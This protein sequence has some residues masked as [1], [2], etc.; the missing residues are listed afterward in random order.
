MQSKTGKIQSIHWST[1]PELLKAI[2]DEFGNYFDPCPLNAQFN[3]LEIDWKETNFINPPYDRKGKELFIRKAYAEWKKGKTC[4]LLIPVSTSTKIFHELIYGQAEIRFI[5]K[6]IKFGGS[7]SCGTFDSML[8]IFRGKDCEK[9]NK[10]K[11]QMYEGL[12]E[13]VENL[14]SGWSYEVLE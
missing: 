2:R 4:I 9:S 1:P 8:V 10:I 7:K 6:R 11:I 14:P 13:S 3:G 5:E 12:I